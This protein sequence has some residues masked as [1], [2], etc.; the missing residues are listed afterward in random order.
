MGNRSGNGMGELEQDRRRIGEG[1]TVGDGKDVAARSLDL[2]GG[3]AG[4]VNPPGSGPS[5]SP[6]R[7]STPASS[8]STKS[9]SLCRRTPTVTACR[10][11]WTT[12][13]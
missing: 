11:G 9:P 1:N 4:P 12:A 3:A 2:L 7:S 10:T 6:A 8:T 5:T 13:R